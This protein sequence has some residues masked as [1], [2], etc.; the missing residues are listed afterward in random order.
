LRKADIE[1]FC[2]VPDAGL[3]PFIRMAHED[4]G[5]RPIVLTTEEE[6]VG[7]CLGAWFGGKRAILMTQSSGIGN[8]INNFSLLSNCRIP[9]LALVSMRGEFGETVPWQVPMGR[10]T[11]KY[12]EAAGFSVYSAV[13]PDEVADVVKAGLSMAWRSDERV[14][15]LLSQRLIGAKDV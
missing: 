15:V 2:Y 5:A 8:C 13:R 1:L 7:I 10:G 12:L 11:P 9:F 3:D 6:G 4:P 14:A